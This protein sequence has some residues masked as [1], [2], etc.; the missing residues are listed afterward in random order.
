[1]ASGVIVREFRA[2]GIDFV[3]LHEGLDNSIPNGRLVFGIFASIAE[4]E[5]ELIRDRVPLGLREATRGDRGPMP[6]EWPPCALRG[7]WAAISARNWESGGKGTAQQARVGS[8]PDSSLRAPRY[9]ES[10]GSS[11]D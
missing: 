10:R 7:S 2:L 6:L 1:M 11:H 4:F 3:R 5:Q 9:L 8:M